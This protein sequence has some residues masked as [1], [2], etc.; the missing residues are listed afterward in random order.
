M[1]EPTSHDTNSWF[2]TIWEALHGYREDSISEGDENNDAQW[3]S[4]CTAMAWL[5][6]NY[7]NRHE[8]VIELIRY[9]SEQVVRRRVL[10][11]KLDIALKAMQ[12]AEDL[13]T[14]HMLNELTD[15]ACFEDLP[16]LDDARSRLQEAHEAISSVN[17]ADYGRP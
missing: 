2:A 12:A 8:R 3:S 14:D 6:E 15:T 16:E 17:P 4:I 11:A 5:K 13:V 1:T 9:N 10:Q 7:D